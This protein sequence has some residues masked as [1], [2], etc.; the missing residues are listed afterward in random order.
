MTEVVNPWTDGNQRGW[1]VGTPTGL[2]RWCCYVDPEHGT[3]RRLQQ[4]FKVEL[5]IDRKVAGIT[6]VWHDVEEH[7]E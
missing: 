6:L 4:Q 7:N 2:L 3:V 5:V 1:T